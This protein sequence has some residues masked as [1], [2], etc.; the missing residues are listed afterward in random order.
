M[1][2]ANSCQRKGTVAIF[3]LLVH[4][5]AE[6]GLLALR[7]KNPT[8]PFQVWV[9]VLCPTEQ[10]LFTSL[11][12]LCV[13]EIGLCI[14]EEALQA[15]G[16]CLE[17]FFFKSFKRDVSRTRDRRLLSPVQYMGTCILERQICM[18]KYIYICHTRLSIHSFAN[19][20]F[21]TINTQPLYMLYIDG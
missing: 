11:M 4:W 20:I 17:P 1:G 13:L 16:L 18:S 5:Y 21:R 12:F 3:A 15:H 9:C 14:R 19:S 10:H 6:Q 7:E 2:N 8:Q